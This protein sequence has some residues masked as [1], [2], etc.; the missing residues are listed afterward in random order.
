MGMWIEL[1]IFVLVLLFG[2]HQIWDVKR[3]QRKRL[4]QKSDPEA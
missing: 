4:Q 3:E 1:G 2:L